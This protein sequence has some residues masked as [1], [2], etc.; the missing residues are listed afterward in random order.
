MTVSY[1]T[2][3]NGRVLK[4]AITSEADLHL[5]YILAEETVSDEAGKR[6]G[7]SVFAAVCGG[8][9]G[10]DSAFIRD[11]T[12]RADEAEE[13]FSLITNGA[14]TPCTLFDA[15]EDYIASR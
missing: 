12:A 15:A 13:F 3:I 6:S 10:T 9:A 5:S 1:E 7:Y 2:A 11:L 4:T 14:V 8:D